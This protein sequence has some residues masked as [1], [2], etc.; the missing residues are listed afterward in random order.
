MACSLALQMEAGTVSISRYLAIL[1]YVPFGGA[2]NF[3]R[4]IHATARSI[5]PIEGRQPRLDSAAVRS[6]A[7]RKAR[8]VSR[9]D[10]ASGKDPHPRRDL[11]Q[12]LRRRVVGVL[13][14]RRAAIDLVLDARRGLPGVP[15]PANGKSQRNLTP[16]ASGAGL[17]EAARRFQPRRSCDR[18]ARPLGANPSSSPLETRSRSEVP[19][20]RHLPLAR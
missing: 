15:G 12:F 16:E 19:E 4:G 11:I 10:G 20:A 6:P 8:S 3:G 18:R 9:L 5:S 14:H 2:K 13:L 1:P 17:D 7:S